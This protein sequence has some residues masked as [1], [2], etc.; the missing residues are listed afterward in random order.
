MVGKPPGTEVPLDGSV[1]T[2]PVGRRPWIPFSALK[3]GKEKKKQL[4]S[5]TVLVKLSQSILLPISS[6][7]PVSASV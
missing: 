3:R 7:L 1:L 4:K 2:H 5:Y 6:I